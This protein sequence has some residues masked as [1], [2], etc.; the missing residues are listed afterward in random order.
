MADT[1]L[2]DNHPVS[3]YCKPTTVDQYGLPLSA[4]FMPRQGEEYLSANWLEY[5]GGPASDT[6]IDRVRTVFGKRAFG[7]YAMVGLYSSTSALRRL[8]FTRVSGTPLLRNRRG[9]WDKNLLLF[10]PHFPSIT[11]DEF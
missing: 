7:L 2:P 6:T 11:G 4:A 10:K 3:R 5:F 8:R 9:R 1:T